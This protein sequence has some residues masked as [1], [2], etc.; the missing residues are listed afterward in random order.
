MMI[1][2]IIGRNPCED[3]CEDPREAIPGPNPAAPAVKLAVVDEAWRQI[4]AIG[5]VAG[6]ARALGA[7]DGLMSGEFGDRLLAAKSRMWHP[8]CIPRGG[9]SGSQV[10][11][12][13]TGRLTCW[14]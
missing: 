12:N 13:E 9:A 7:G 5:A 4:L 2:A 10:P 11:I 6:L 8:V 1:D 14:F 3:A